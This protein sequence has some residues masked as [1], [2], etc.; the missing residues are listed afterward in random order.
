[1]VERTNRRTKER[2]TAEEPAEHPVRGATFVCGMLM[3]KAHFDTLRRQSG[4]QVYLMSARPTKSG[5]A[6]AYRV[7]DCDTVHG[8]AVNT[9]NG[10]MCEVP[11]TWV[12]YPPPLSPPLSARI[13]ARLALF[14]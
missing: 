13:T 14:G 2:R 7:G 1:M 9:R 11:P 10:V 3:L 6:V 4:Q 8:M 5:W 12:A